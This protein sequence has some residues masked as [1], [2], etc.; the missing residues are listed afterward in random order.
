MCG[1]RIRNLVLDVEDPYVRVVGK[2]DVVRDC[3]LPA[4]LVEA[5][6]AYLASR[7]ERT[8]QPAR[9]DDLLWLNN[10]GAPLTPTTLD[11]YV[12]RWFWRARVPLPSG[13]QAHAFRHT[14][15]MQLVG[16][17]E[18]LNV[19][20]ALL[21]HASLRSTEIYIR[22]AGHHV[23]EAAHL[24]PVRGQLRDMSRESGV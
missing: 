9:R 7:L 12:R 10:H 23:R 14:V 4:E 2:G 17:G 16:R 20:Q 18:A 1:I 22:A 21:G 6:E 11:H 24:L 19:V 8:K 15:A 5:I 3:P 13:A